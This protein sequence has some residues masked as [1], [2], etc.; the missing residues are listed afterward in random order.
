MIEKELEN[1]FT[2]LEHDH[3]S[4]V[5]EALNAAKVACKK[6]GERLTPLRLKVLEL[7][8]RSHSPVGA[9]DLLEMLREERGRVAPPTV[10][11]ALEFLCRQGFVHRLDSLQAFIGCGHPTG[12]YE[13]NHSAHFLICQDCGMALEIRDG[14]LEGAI[15]GLVGRLD[16][17]ITDETIELSGICSACQP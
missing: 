3:D 13:G 10:Y 9:Y 14:P 1:P 8:W 15:E 4:C 11:R 5:V 17:A 16:F 7:I 2:D 6:S 12:H